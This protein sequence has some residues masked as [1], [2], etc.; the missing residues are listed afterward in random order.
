MIRLAPFEILL[1][2]RRL[3]MLRPLMHDPRGDETLRRE[4]RTSGSVAFIRILP[5]LHRSKKV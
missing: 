1:S 5:S 3:L 4:R 2:H